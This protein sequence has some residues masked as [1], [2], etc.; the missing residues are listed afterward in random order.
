MLSM[1]TE[2]EDAI[3]HACGMLDLLSAYL[4][5]L[6]RGGEQ[7]HPEPPWVSHIRILAGTTRHELHQ[8]WLAYYDEVSRMQ[9][10]G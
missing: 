7:N 5:D 10:R 8:Q 4:A 9:R 6:E 2:F 1:T 3:G